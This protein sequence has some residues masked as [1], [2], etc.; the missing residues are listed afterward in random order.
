[1]RLKQKKLLLSSFNRQA[2]NYCFLGNFE[3]SLLCARRAFD[4]MSW[5][6]EELR[7]TDGQID[8]NDLIEIADPAIA[9]RYYQSIALWHVGYADQALAQI[10]EAVRLSKSAQHAQATAI[11]LFFLAFIQQ[12]RGDTGGLR[13]TARELEEFTSTHDL[14]LWHSG[15][16]VLLGYA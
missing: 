14:R 15:A 13:G 9:V 8:I 11:A 1:Y 7:G 4:L 2:S 10:N 12:F 16:E 5:F 3:A 6:P